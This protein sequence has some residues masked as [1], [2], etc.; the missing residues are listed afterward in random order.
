[1]GRGVSRK[2][3]S[4]RGFSGGRMRAIRSGSCLVGL[5]LSALPSTGAFAAETFSAE[6]AMVHVRALSETIGPRKTGTPG[7]GR[8]RDYIADQMRRLGLEVRRLPVPRVGDTLVGSEDII[9]V[10]PGTIPDAVLIGSHHDSRASDV[11][12]ANDD[13][14]AVGVMLETARVLFA[15]RPIA[16]VVFAS[17]CA[18]EEGLLGARFYAETQDLSRIRVVVNMDPVGQREIFVSPFPFAPSLWASR[19]VAAVAAD[20]KIPGVIQDPLYLLVTRSVEIP[21]AAD[22]EPFL[23]KGVPALSL[24][25]RFRA[26][27]YHTVE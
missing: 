14:S 23:D 13:A 25:D 17:F 12:G 15:D 9:G 3:A 22:H 20:G 8:A 21:F 26:W 7:E 27:T 11:P 4:A 18:E 10:L 5:I 1:M 6:R 24:S 16:T 19:A 2:A